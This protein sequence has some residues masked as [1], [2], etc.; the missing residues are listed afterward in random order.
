MVEHTLGKGEVTS[1][2]LVTGFSEVLTVVRFQGFDGKTENLDF[3]SMITGILTENQPY[4]KAEGRNLRVLIK[5]LVLSLKPSLKK[6][7]Y[8]DTSL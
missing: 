5:N 3:I 7:L 2:I 8:K 1:S 6:E 4:K